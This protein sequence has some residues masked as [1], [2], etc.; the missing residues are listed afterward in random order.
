M[1]LLIISVDIY[2]YF[3]FL[4]MWGLNYINKDAE[5]NVKVCCDCNHD[6]FLWPFEMEAL[7]PWL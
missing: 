6:D 3:S 7:L 5:S 4:V 1:S 2:I